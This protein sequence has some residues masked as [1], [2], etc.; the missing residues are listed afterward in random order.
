MVLLYNTWHA[1]FSDDISQAVKGNI[2]QKK[3]GR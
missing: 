2:R 1:D 3:Q